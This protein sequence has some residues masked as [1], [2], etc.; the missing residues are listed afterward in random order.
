MTLT[1]CATCDQHGPD[2]PGLAGAD[3]IELHRALH[4]LGRALEAHPMVRAVKALAEALDRI[5]GTSKADYVLIPPLP[6]PRIPPAPWAGA[7][8]TSTGDTRDDTQGKP[9]R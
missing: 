3:G 5:G 7:G 4:D 2:L 6:G 9:P 1:G 8:G